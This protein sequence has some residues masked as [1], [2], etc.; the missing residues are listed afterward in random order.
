MKGFNEIAVIGLVFGTVAVSVPATLSVAA[1][2]ES[3]ASAASVSAA[4][5]VR[6]KPRAPRLRSSAALVMD[7]RE[8]VV[9]YGRKVDERHPIASVTKLMTAMVTL[10]KRSRSSG[11]IVTTSSMGSR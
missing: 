1:E 6:L 7:E 4:D 11:M 3:Y 2:E 10:R 9:L 8:G 5:I